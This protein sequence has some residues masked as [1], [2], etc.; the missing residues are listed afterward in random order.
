[1]PPL[2]AAESRCQILPPDALHTAVTQPIAAARCR[3]GATASRLSSGRPRPLRWD[4]ANPATCRSGEPKCNLA[5][6]SS[7]S[8]TC[9]TDLEREI[10]ICIPMVFFIVLLD[11]K[12]WFLS[13]TVTDHLFLAIDCRFPAIVRRFLK[14]P[15][16]DHN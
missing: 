15:K 11:E 14:I 4:L 12:L 3:R 5:S 8:Q 6:R 13:L 10:K 9:N 7:H 1:M 2:A 16:Q